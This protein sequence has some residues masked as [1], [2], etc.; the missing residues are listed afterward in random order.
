[1]FEALY[2]VGGARGFGLSTIVISYSDALQCGFV[3]D[4]DCPGDP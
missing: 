1:M 4:A 3:V 2:P